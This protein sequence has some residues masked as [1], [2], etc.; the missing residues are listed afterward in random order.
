MYG[1]VLDS[2]RVVAEPLATMDVMNHVP[3]H[4]KG[5]VPSTQVASIL[6]RELGYKVHEEA[7][8]R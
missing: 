6:Q 8:S 1:E 2:Q 7:L 5:M 4:S 3:Q